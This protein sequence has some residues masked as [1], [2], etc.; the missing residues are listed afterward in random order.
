MTFEI[1]KKNYSLP[2]VRANKKIGY[3]Y[4]ENRYSL[5]Y[6]KY[7]YGGGSAIIRPEPN[8][9]AIVTK[10]KYDYNTKENVDYSDS[11]E[12]FK[13]F[14]ETNEILINK[15]LNSE[16]EKIIFPQGFATD[17][18]K[19]P[20]RFAEWLQKELLENFGLITELNDKKTGLICKEITIK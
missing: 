8:A 3:V 20:T 16:K 14:T 17:K 9:Y 4:T 11:D 7:R 13:E 18:A 12:D 2:D 15:I 5:T 6:F 1:T 10:K 19:M